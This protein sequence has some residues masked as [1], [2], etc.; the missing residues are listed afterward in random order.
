MH[1]WCGDLGKFPSI[2]S[3]F[4]KSPSVLDTIRPN[5]LN[6]RNRCPFDGFNISGK[7]R[8]VFSG[9]VIIWRDGFT[10]CDWIR[11]SRNNLNWVSLLRLQASFHLVDLSS[12]A[13]Q[14]L[15]QLRALV[16]ERRSIGQYL[17]DLWNVIIVEVPI[18]L[19]FITLTLLTRGW[20]QPRCIWS[21]ETSQCQLSTPRH[22]ATKLSKVCISSPLGYKE[23]VCKT[24]FRSDLSCYSC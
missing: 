16:D 2:I 13:K 17:L 6:A 5:P 23:H 22:D 11:H 1:L 3:A 24:C 15:R 14:A 19:Y 4:V 12:L 8:I 9:G 10:R 20:A 21:L 18:G 7:N